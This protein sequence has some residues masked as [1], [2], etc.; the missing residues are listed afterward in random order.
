MLFKMPLIKTLVSR[1]KSHQRFIFEGVGYDPHVINVLILG[2]TV[3]LMIVF[4]FKIFN[5]YSQLQDSLMTIEG[6]IKVIYICRIDMKSFDIGFVCF[7]LE[8]QFFQ[9]H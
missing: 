8:G 6:E 4:S 3:L 5:R 7:L 9:I 2:D 1:I